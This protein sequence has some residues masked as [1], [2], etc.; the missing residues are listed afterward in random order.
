MVVVCCG[1]LW[2][3]VAPYVVALSLKLAVHVLITG[4]ASLKSAQMSL[5]IECLSFLMCKR[6]EHGLLAWLQGDY[7]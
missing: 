2:C 5:K 7:K 6:G 4:D 1:V 3:G